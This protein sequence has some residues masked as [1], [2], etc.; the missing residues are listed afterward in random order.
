MMKNILSKILKALKS[1]RADKKQNPSDFEAVT[2]EVN[3]VTKTT[4][5]SQVFQGQLLKLIMLLVIILGGALGLVAFM[6]NKAK[7]KAVRKPAAEELKVELAEKAIDGEVLWRQHHE[8]EMKK[9]EEELKGR[10]KQA[11]ELLESARKK[12]TDDTQNEIR[13]L[14]EQLKMARSELAESNSNMR[15]LV[16]REEERLNASPGHKASEINIEGFE[17]GVEY[18]IPKSAAMYIPEGTYFTG[19]LLG[20]IVVSTALNTPDENATPLTIRLTGR[21]NLSKANELD[22]SKCRIQG[23]SYGD[24]SSERAIIRLEKLICEEEGMYI[25]SSIAGDVHGPDGFNGIKGTVVSTGSKHIKN[26][27]IGGLISGVTSSAKGQEGMNITAG[28]LIS[29]QSMG[30]KDMAK[31]GVLSGASNA[32]DKIADYYLR[33][34]ESMSPVLTIPGGVRINAHITKGFFVGEVGTHKR[35]KQDREGRALD[36]KKINGAKE[37]DRDN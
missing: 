5:N 11:E 20:G 35:I 13:D 21:G 33:Q 14:K 23:S 34:A 31:Q 22:I 32:G 29:T 10:L 25:T 24:L 17:D 6:Q 26:A 8:E 16:S 4:N 2:S 1:G 9:L 28:G 12:L 7:L 15:D 18:D 30:F 3:E 27:M 19:Y 37:D 36:R